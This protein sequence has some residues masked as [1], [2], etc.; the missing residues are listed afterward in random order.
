MKRP[1][2]IFTL[3]RN[4]SVFLPMWL[5]YYARTGAHLHVLDHASDDG[6]TGPSEIP[7]ECVPVDRSTTDDAEWMLRVVEVYQRELLTQYETVI[8][9]ETD[10]FLVPDP[11]YRGGLKEYLSA[12]FDSTL[13]AVGFN[14]CGTVESPRLAGAADP[15]A[16]RLWRRDDRYDKTL[17]SRVPLRW[18][19]GFHRP[20]HGDANR[21]AP[22]PGLYL[23]HLHYACRETAWERLCARMRNR[24]PDPGD[25]G[26]QNKFQDRG[27]FD[28]NFD[29]MTAGAVAIPEWARG[30]LR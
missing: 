10:E 16:G 26:F 6:S 24:S 25:L 21:H 2:A 1:L 7:F 18:E 22:D 19:V 14:V 29:E 9:A 15:L 11:H 17:I 3:S 23:L 13:T 5:R 27:K 12:R 4:E 30:A 8:Y 28:R 20:A